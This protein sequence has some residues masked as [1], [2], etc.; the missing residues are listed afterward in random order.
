MDI[1]EL[2]QRRANPGGLTAEELSLFSVVM[3]RSLNHQQS[4]D[5]VE[6]LAAGQ[7]FQ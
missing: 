3:F 2:V 5:A 1:M 4:A 6:H 7:P